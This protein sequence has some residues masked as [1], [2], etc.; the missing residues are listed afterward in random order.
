MKTHTIKLLK[1]YQD[2][3]DRGQIDRKLSPTHPERQKSE[4]YFRDNY[5]FSHGP[6][7]TM[8]YLGHLH[9]VNNQRF[10]E[11]FGTHTSFHTGNKTKLTN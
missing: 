3:F 10:D 8:Y 4:N 6:A 9:G 2:G 5:H 7:V 11:A 1:E